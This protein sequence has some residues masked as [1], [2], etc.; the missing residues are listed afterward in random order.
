MIFAKKEGQEIITHTHSYLQYILE[1]I[2]QDVSSTNPLPNKSQHT[3]ARLPPTTNHRPLQQQSQILWISSKQTKISVAINNS[4]IHHNDNLE[5][6]EFLLNTK[7]SAAILNSKAHHNDNRP[8][9]H[10]HRPILTT[11]PKSH[12]KPITTPR[13]ITTTQSWTRHRFATILTP[14]VSSYIVVSIPL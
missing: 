14:F 9:L 4:T 2:L 8:H 12:H 13:P 3:P 1:F 11:Y 5:F 10:S 7:I 6:F